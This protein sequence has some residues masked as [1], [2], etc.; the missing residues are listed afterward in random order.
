[1]SKLIEH[2]NLVDGFNLNPI[3]MEA[4]QTMTT[5]KWLMGIQDKVNKIID[6]GNQWEIQ[7]NEYTDEQA[8]ILQAEINEL[9]RM[10]ETGEIVKDGS[11]SFA[12]FN[13]S[14][15]EDFNDTII[16]AIHNA[17]KFVTFGLDKDYFCAWIPSTW[18]EIDFSTSE[19][20]E[21]C[22]EILEQG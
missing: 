19:N 11:L 6:L 5:T 7:A 10:V 1:M 12:K 15:L 22:L 9:M 8:K 13:K 14:F 21:L 17:T 2:V 3:S 20:G 4:G 16:Q 18:N